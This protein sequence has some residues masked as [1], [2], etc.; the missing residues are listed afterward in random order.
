[1]LSSIIHVRC[2]FPTNANCSPKEK[3]D[4]NDLKFAVPNEIPLEFEVKEIRTLTKWRHL[5]PDKKSALEITEV[6]QLEMVDHSEPPYA[7]SW[8]TFKGYLAR[9]WSS[10]KSKEGR[11]RGEVP[12]WYEAAVVSLEL[13]GLLAQNARLGVGQKADWEAEDLRARGVF[14]SLY[15]PA[16]QMVREMDHVGRLDDNRLAAKYDNLR[17]RRGNNASRSVP[18]MGAQGARTGQQGQRRTVAVS[19]GPRT[20]GPSQAGG[21]AASGLRGVSR[22]ENALGKR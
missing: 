18:G 2:W 21:M 9:P 20:V 4:G 12:C 17:L 13:E 14:P 8:D 22:S 10:R 5:S 1:M 19:D 16:L 7:G 3:G 15:R 6:V 11:D